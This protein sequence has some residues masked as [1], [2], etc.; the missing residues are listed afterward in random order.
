MFARTVVVV[1]LLGLMAVS[2]N[3]RAQSDD[4]RSKQR[5]PSS[6]LY[7][8]LNGQKGDK[9]TFRDSSGRTQGSA[10]PYGK[11]PQPVEVAGR[12]D[13][14]AKMQVSICRVTRSELEMTNRGPKFF[15]C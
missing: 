4:D 13:G 15:R 12:G 3:C 14:D 7:S 1:S 9:T 11:N 10:I 8:V 5:L 6:Y 2:D